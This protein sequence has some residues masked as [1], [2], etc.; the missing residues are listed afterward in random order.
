ME[1]RAKEPESKPIDSVMSNSPQVAPQI[2][3]NY[4]TKNDLNDMFSKLNKQINPDSA[5]SPEVRSVVKAVEDVQGLRNALKDP[6][7]MGIEQAT[8][9]LVTNL[10]SN[11]LNNISGTNQPA[12]VQKPLLHGLAEIATHNISANLPQVL[13][14]LKTA[15]G[16]ERLQ[17]GYDAGVKYIESKQPDNFVNTVLSLD[18]NNDEHVTY[19]AQQMGYTDFNKAKSI[20]IE[21]K[22][23]LYQEQQEYQNIQQ[24]ENQQ[25][26]TNDDINTQQ[27]NNQQQNEQQYIEEQQNEQ[28]YVEQMHVEQPQNIN[29]EEKFEVPTKIH[30]NNDKIKLKAIDESISVET[31]KEINIDT[32]KKTDEK[33]N[34]MSEEID[35]IF[36]ELTS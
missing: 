30:I 36:D 5:L 28:Q 20:L 33:I 32:D 31:D 27:H 18:E 15:L 21:H 6:T 8:S 9:S 7:S 26:S 14:S 24:G 29:N 23:T 10:L 35:E 3:E 17:K 34:D 11:A 25:Y 1:L 12:A 4:V 19:Y 13:D 16:T 22:V 2:N